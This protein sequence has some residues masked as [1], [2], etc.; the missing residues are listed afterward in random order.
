MSKFADSLDARGAEGVHPPGTQVGRAQ[1]RYLVKQLGGTKA[2]RPECCGS[3]SA[4]S[5]VT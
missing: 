4:P 2:A 3:P 5:T 1:M